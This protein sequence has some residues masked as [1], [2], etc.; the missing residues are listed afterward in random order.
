MISMLYHIL[1]YESLEAA[2]NRKAIFYQSYFE[3]FNILFRKRKRHSVYFV[4][5]QKNPIKR[6]KKMPTNIIAFFLILN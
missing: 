2:E 4:E 1:L 6:E 3:Y 5:K